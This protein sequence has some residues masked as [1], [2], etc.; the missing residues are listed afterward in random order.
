M[1][2]I[3][4]QLNQEEFILWDDFITEQTGGKN[5]KKIRKTYDFF[6]VM[7]KSWL[8]GLAVFPTVIFWVYFFGFSTDKF[9]D[10][11]N[12]SSKDDF[13]IYSL[14]VGFI[15][16]SW[17]SLIFQAKNGEFTRTQDKAEAEILSMMSQAQWYWSVHG[18]NKEKNKEEEKI[19]INQERDLL[20][21]IEPKLNS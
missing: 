8:H 4:F 15:V 6:R 19:V 18:F 10:V 21:R 3:N 2:K 20:G 17:I 16:S 11:V 1:N 5:K 9:E 13:L 7:I 12:S 14:A